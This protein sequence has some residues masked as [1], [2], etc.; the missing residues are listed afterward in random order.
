MKYKKQVGCEVLLVINAIS[1][2][3]SYFITFKVSDLGF[4]ES[5]DGAEV[6]PDVCTWTLLVIK[7]IHPLFPLRLTS[8]FLLGRSIPNQH[9]H[10]E[11]GVL[12]YV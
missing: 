11:K 1:H 9:A 7:F 5:G 12:V 8:P 4:M 10:L 3:I 6:F 2:V